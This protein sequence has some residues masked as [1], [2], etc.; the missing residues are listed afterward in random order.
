MVE[1]GQ[2]R[3]EV[4]FFES[5][6]GADA[7]SRPKHSHQDRVKLAHESACARSAIWKANFAGPEFG[8]V[9]VH[10]HCMD[11]VIMITASAMVVNAYRESSFYEQHNF[12]DLP[13]PLTLNTLKDLKDA[14]ELLVHFNALACFV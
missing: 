9:G 1:H 2:N 5:S 3:H 14:V 4:V 8:V 10:L 7:K 6:L 13:V 11:N 12:F